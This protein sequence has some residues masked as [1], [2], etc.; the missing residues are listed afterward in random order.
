MPLLSK[1][2]KEGDEKNLAPQTLIEFE[3]MKETLLKCYDEIKALLDK[4]YK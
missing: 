1:L 3:E 4:N 2:E